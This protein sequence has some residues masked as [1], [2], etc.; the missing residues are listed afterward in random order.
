MILYD[1]I[2]EWDGKQKGGRRPVC[3]WPGKYRIRIIRLNVDT[4]GVHYLKTHAVLCHNMGKGTSIKNYIQ[5][6]ARRISEEYGIDMEKTLW[7]EFLDYPGDDIVVAQMDRMANMVGKRLYSCSW[8]PIRTNESQM[9][10]PYMK[11]WP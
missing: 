1:G 9:L 7:V 3:W 6:F 10:V 2:Y 5:N 11:D 8:R 4:P